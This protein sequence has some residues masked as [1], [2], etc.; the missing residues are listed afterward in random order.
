MSI[1][2]GIYEHY[3]GN[4]YRTIGT[5]RHSETREELV[6]YRALYNSPEFG[7]NALWVR[8]QQ[9]FLENVVIDGVS[10]PRFK[11]IARTLSEAKKKI[12]LKK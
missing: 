4:L 12:K 11:Y 9:M 5:V 6:L 8:P 2:E 7:R 10:V 1:R 3:K